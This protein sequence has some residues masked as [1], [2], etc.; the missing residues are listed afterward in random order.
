VLRHKTAAH[1][2]AAARDREYLLAQ[3]GP[4]VLGG[5]SQMNRLLATMDEVAAKVG[6]RS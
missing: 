4:Q 5:V 3:Y 6:G 1:V 2:E